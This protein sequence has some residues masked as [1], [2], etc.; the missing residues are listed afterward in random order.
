MYYFW[1][2]SNG[3]DYAY[4]QTSEMSVKS[5]E[6]INGTQDLF[7]TNRRWSFCPEFALIHPDTHSP[8]LQ[9]FA[10]YIT[11]VK[12]NYLYTI[13]FTF[14][15][16]FFCSMDHVRTWPYNCII[17]F[18]ITDRFNGMHDVHKEQDR[19]NTFGLNPMGETMYIQK[20]L[21]CM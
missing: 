3:W 16:N 17:Y 1:L 10:L 11:T 21:W 12:H 14:T 5:L 20:H 2:E 9:I 18:Q 7:H 4:T 8:P 19:C 13:L 15:D 6:N